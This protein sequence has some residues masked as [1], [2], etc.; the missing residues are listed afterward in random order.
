MIDEFP[1]ELRWP[2]TSIGQRIGVE[3]SVRDAISA[4]LGEWLDAPG[5]EV[6][7]AYRGRDAL[8]GREVSWEGAGIEPGSG[9]AA[10]VDER[11]NLVVERD[12]GERLSLGSGEVSLRLGPRNRD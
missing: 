1:A 9:R 4:A 11:G 6:L 10:G 2:A 12:R 3:P 5:G 7:A 8:R